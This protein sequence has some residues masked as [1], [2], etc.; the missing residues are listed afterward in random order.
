MELK[1]MV[2]DGMELRE[3][4]TDGKERNEMTRNCLSGQN[5]EENSMR[6]KTE[7]CESE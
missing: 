2:T 6:E 7:E 3:M 1:K 5:V 4:V